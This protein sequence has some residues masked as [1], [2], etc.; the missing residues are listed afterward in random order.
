MIASVSSVPLW[1]YLLFPCLMVLLTVGLVYGALYPFLKD[2]RQ[3]ADDRE[4]RE[5]RIDATVDVVLGRDADPKHGRAPIVGLINLQADDRRRLKKID[6][7]IGSINGSGKTV[8]QMV[9][10]IDHGLKE[11]IAADERRFAGL[12]HKLDGV[13]KTVT[14]LAE[15]RPK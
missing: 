8:I 6:E 5:D 13:R 3:H 7:T 15:G 11:H 1:A 14:E 2:R 10:G 4:S 12:D 9:E